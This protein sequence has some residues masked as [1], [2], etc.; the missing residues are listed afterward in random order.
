MAVLSLPFELVPPTES[1]LSLSPP[2]VFCPHD[3]PAAI[4]AGLGATE[5]EAVEAEG[6]R[7]PR[8]RFPGDLV[9]P[10]GRTEVL[11]EVLPVEEGTR[12]DRSSDKKCEMEHDYHECKLL[13]NSICKTNKAHFVIMRENGI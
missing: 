9:R 12:S 13:V 5:D 10:A 2:E 4:G 7:D 6:G 1:F 8:S 11:V 3:I